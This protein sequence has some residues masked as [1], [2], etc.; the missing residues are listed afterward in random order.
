MGSSHAV[1]GAAAWLAVGAASIPSLGLYDVG[2]AMVLLGLPIAAGAALLPDADHHNATIAH[3]IPVAGRVAA[4]VVG[5]VSGGHRKGMHSFLAVAAVIIGMRHLGELLWTP[6]GWDRPFHLGA[7]IAVAACVTFAAKS[8]KLAKS[9]PIA[10]LTG[11]VLG[12]AVGLM[13]PEATA[14]LPWCIGTGYLV[15]LIGD[16]LTTGG[17]PLFW[18]IPIKPPRWVQQTPILNRMWLPGGGFA[19][20]VLGDTGSWREQ[21]LFLALSAYAVWGLCSE[22]VLALQTG[23]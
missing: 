18:P 2:P 7:A 3:S 19:V 23:L 5:A 16:M 20:P 22:A 14:W 13:A 1:S 21:G 6:S 8:L 9:W 10:W 11:I 17:V 12:C 4:G 15:H